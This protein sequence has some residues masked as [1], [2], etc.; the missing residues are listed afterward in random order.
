NGSALCFYPHRPS[1]GDINMIHKRAELFV[2]ASYEEDFLTGFPFA[3]VL[4]VEIATSKKKAYASAVER[5]PDC[6]I[7]GPLLWDEVPPSVRLQALEADRQ[8][9]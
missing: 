7:L 2:I 6:E 5:W 8:I 9:S 4:G 3:N 1:M